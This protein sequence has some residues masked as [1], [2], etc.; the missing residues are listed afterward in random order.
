MNVLLLAYFTLVAFD[1]S[2]EADRPVLRRGMTI[3][4]DAPSGNSLGETVNLVDPDGGD[5][6]AWQKTV[7]NGNGDD[8]GVFDTWAFTDGSTTIASLLI[9]DS[10]TVNDN[11][12]SV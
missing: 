4:G 9:E 10:I 8:Q 6:F 2:P 12:A 5:A 3:L 11:V 1:V 7:D